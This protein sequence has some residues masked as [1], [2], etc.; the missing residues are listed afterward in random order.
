M[1]DIA[2]R[3]DYFDTLRGIGIILM[4]MGHIGFGIAFDKYIHAFHMPLFFFVA[5]YFFTIKG[6]SSFLSFTMQS[7]KSLLVPYLV[8]CVLCQLLHYIYAGEW[9]FKYF[10][11]SLVSSN[12]NRIDV[13]GAYWF[14][15]CLFST[16]LLYYGINQ[17]CRGW[18]L[19][20]VICGLTVFGNLRLVKLPLCLDSSLSMLLAI[21]M[22]TLLRQYSESKILKKIQRMSVLSII[23]LMLINGILIFENDFV[24]IRTNSVGVI[25]L[26]WLNVTTAIMCYLLIS[27]RL[28][29][30]SNKMVA[31][32]C[33][34]L[35]YIGRNS[36]VYLVL[37]ELVIF[38][39]RLVLSFV[40]VSDNSY[41]RLNIFVLGTSMILMAISAEII[42]RTKL[43]IV[44]GK[45]GK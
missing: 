39:V 14:L 2:N 42:N 30:C 31:I 26:F 6:G 23:V 13:A 44:I 4:V 1:K 8:F 34:A 11:L 12:H 35:N 25:P 5:G 28:N 32:L 36:I 10:L 37:N 18:I 41:V 33:T 21:H 19:T 24:N 40:G 7:V 15:L 3:I 45:F 29:E 17:L 22:G 27:K 38:S 9:S 20:I 43:R 16:R